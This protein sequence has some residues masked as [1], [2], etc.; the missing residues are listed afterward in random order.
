MAALDTSAVSS[1]GE[2]ECWGQIVVIDKSGTD[3]DRLDLFDD[4]PYKFGRCVRTFLG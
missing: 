1:E 3:L 2:Q 4:E